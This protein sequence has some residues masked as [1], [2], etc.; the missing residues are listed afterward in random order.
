M[1]KINMFSVLIVAIMFQFLVFIIPGGSVLAEDTSSASATFYEKDGWS[2]C[3]DAAWPH[4]AWNNLDA[5][6]FKDSIYRG[7]TC[8][9]DAICGWPNT[10][11]LIRY[12]SFKATDPLLSPRRSL[13]WNNPI[14]MSIF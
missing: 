1:H 9:P 3:F 4:H 8:Y 10:H 5:I 2:Q 7:W 11:M 12:Y 13:N 6:Y 14:R